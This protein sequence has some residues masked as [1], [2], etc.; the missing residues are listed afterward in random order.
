[1]TEHGAASDDAGIT[2]IEVILY[3]LLSSLILIAVSMIL[4]T[5]LN[6]QRDVAGVTEATSRGQGM[7]AVIERALH[8]G[9]AFDVSADG[10]QL[11]VRTSLEGNLEC[12]AF[13]LTDGQARMTQS[14]S[15]IP[16]DPSTWSNWEQNVL[17]DGAAPY[18]DATGSSVSYSFTIATDSAPVRI[19]G[20]AAVRAVATGVTAPC[21]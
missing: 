1:M 17:P 5:S 19:S 7:G 15:A 11:R 4:I 16:S 18:F 10:T 9:L 14:A 2:L 20:Q 13:L 8:N 12:Q 6:T 21:W 3:V